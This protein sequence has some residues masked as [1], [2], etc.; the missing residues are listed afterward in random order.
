M[1]NRSTFPIS[2]DAFIENTEISASDRP[3]LT[4][5][6]ELKLKASRTPNEDDELASLTNTLR[7]KLM[8]AEDYNHM[9]DAIVN[10]Q[11]FFR[12]ETDGYI[13][14][15]QTEFQSELDKFTHRGE[16]N[17]T[18]QYR[19]KNTVTFN[20][21]TY[22]CLKD[23]I[24]TAP[25]NSITTEF[26]A[27][28]AARGSKG[29][30]GDAGTG[31][32]F[33]GSWIA[34]KQYYKDDAV[35]YGG[36]IFACLQNVL[37]NEPNSNADTPYWSLAVAR[38]ESTQLAVIEKTVIVTN[39]TTNVSFGITE[40]NPS[41]DMLL[42][43]K[44]T[45]TLVKGLNYSI[46]PNGISIDSLEDSWDGNVQPINFHFIVFKNFVVDLTLS[47]GT[48]LQDGSVSNA[49]LSADIQIGS[50]ANLNTTA[51]TNV[52]NAINDVNSNVRI[53]INKPF[54]VE[55]RTSD[56]VNPIIGQM[57]FRSDL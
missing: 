48:M 42:V 55:V 15:K 52:V 32:R 56:P 24:G 28:I 45:T 30:Q 3:L 29:D 43:I 17:S 39:Q 35:Q 2:I 22:L 5:Y 27:K 34:S 41:T 19:K 13:Q 54:A 12:D 51:K 37:G 1:A 23:V 33:Q 40:F 44:N 11:S 21:E 4:R 53:N 8:T 18:V 38:G 50:L 10:L 16:F 31:L 49:K 47:D 26:W 36:Q 7:T 57:W 46:N 25:S 14:T 6:Q 20:G 9:K